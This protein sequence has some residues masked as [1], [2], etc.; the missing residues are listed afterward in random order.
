MDMVLDVQ[1]R[2][3]RAHMQEFFSNVEQG[4]LVRL[5]LNGLHWLM[6]TD[7]GYEVSRDMASPEDSNRFAEEENRDS[8]KVRRVGSVTGYVAIA[9]G[10]S[11]L[12]RSGP[13]NFG[14]LLDYSDNYLSVSPFDLHS[15]INAYG[16]IKVPLSTISKY[17]NLRKMFEDNPC[18]SPRQNLRS[19]NWPD[20]DAKRAM[21]GEIEWFEEP[22]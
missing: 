5:H 10:L 1:N 4:D 12:D 8:L 16:A 14:S 13:L 19:P 11:E 21:S 3:L 9:L 17:F 20:A 7:K 18:A 6:R 2:Q 22:A 15:G